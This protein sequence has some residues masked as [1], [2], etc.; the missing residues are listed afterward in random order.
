MLEAGSRRP[1]ELPADAPQLLAAARCAAL[2]NDS[3]LS[4]SEERG[5]YQ[6]MGEATEVAL[7]VLAEKAREGGGCGGRD[8]GAGLGGACR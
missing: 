4:Y 7:R 5:G 1:V 6:R 3:R 8:Q 2:C